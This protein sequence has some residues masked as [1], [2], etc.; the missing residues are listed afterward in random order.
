MTS[1]INVLTHLLHTTY[2][3]LCQLSFYC[4]LHDLVQ[5]FNIVIKLFKR[6]LVYREDIFKLVVNI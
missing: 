1:A 3:N 6:T 2:Y 4:A 5:I